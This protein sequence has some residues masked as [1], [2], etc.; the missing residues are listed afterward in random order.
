M[1]KS[2]CV[3]LCIGMAVVASAADPGKNN[4][5]FGAAV[6]VDAIGGPDGFG[7]SYID[8]TESTGFQPTYNFIDITATGT[9]MGLSDDGEGDATISFSFPYYGNG[10]TQARVGNNGGLFLGV[11]TGDFS[12]GNECPIPSTSGST[13]PRVNVFWDDID[14]ETGDVYYQNL[15][16]C[17]HPDCAGACF[18]LEWFDRPHY[19][20]TGSAT[21]E[22]I[23]CDSGD[24]IAQYEDL[25]FGDPSFD[26]GASATVGIEDEGQDPTYFLEYSC[27][28][29]DLSDGLAILY[30]TGPV[31]VDL[32]SL[33]VE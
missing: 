28:T 8:S 15:A 30:T 18:I 2:L 10:Y 23:L 19:N 20:N 25:D 5:V 7:Y 4:E 21:F 1:R 17:P 6:G 11:T 13:A 24:I 16:S 27:N 22:V 9:A 12:A 3:C 14:S 32:M 29:A 33:S 26:Y 31:P